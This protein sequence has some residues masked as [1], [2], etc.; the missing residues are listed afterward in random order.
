MLMFLTIKCRPDAD[1]ALVFSLPLAPDARVPFVNPFAS[2][3]PLGAG[4]CEVA[5]R[6]WRCH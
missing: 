5:G 4:P 3:G 6:V 1:G 2:V